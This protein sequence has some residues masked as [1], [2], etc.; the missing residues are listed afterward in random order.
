LVRGTGTKGSR[1]YLSQQVVFLL[2]INVALACRRSPPSSALVPEPRSAVAAASFFSGADPRAPSS[3]GASPTPPLVPE[4]PLV[5]EPS[6]RRR[7]V[8]LL[9][10]PRARRPVERRRRPSLPRPRAAEERRR[11]SSPSRRRAAILLLRLPR[12][13]TVLELLRRPARPARWPSHPLL[14]RS[15][16]ATA[17]SFFGPG[18]SRE[19]RRRLLL[20]SIESCAAG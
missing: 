9:Q 13:R 20:A 10:Q 6:S 14:L 16:R 2:Q 17:A 7:C 1:G 5:P 15:S 4:R 19:R 3:R 12:A 18:A 8:L 11:R